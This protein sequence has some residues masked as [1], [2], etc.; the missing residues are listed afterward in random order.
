MFFCLQLWGRDHHC[1]TV[2]LNCNETWAVLKAEWVNKS[3]TRVWKVGS[4]KI[5]SL[6]L[7]CFCHRRSLLS[8]AAKLYAYWI[9]VNFR[10][11]Y[12]MFAVNGILFNHES[13]RRG[14]L[15][16]RHASCWSMSPQRWVVFFL[17]MWKLVLL[18]HLIVIDEKRG[19]YTAQRALTQCHIR[20]RQWFWFKLILI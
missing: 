9:V 19:E 15:T 5:S 12:D 10:E 3:I 7:M 4:G 14:E 6:L 2:C 8:G 17:L 18:Q 13:P 20:A 11:A 1:F 16:A